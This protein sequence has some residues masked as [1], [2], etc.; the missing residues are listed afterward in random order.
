MSNYKE[1]LIQ[2][3]DAFSLEEDQDKQK[4]LQAEIWD[5]LAHESQLDSEDHHIWGLSYYMSEDEKVH[6]TAQALQHFLRALELD[7]ANFMACLYAA[8][9]YHDQGKLSEALRYYEQVDQAGLKAFQ[10]W[11]HV[12]L[13]EQIG[14]C[15]YK[16]GDEKRGRE[17]FAEVLSW[18]QKS[19]TEGLAI[20]VEMMQCLP[21]SDPIIVEMKKIEDY[22]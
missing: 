21:E 4:Q 22:L 1:I 3:Y 16:L 7:P 20:P 9:C 18:Y 6:R 15:H 2:K 11:R 17:L 10:V 8:H 5:L 14:F 12:K 19:D 13:I